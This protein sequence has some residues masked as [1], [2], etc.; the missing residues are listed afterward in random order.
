[1]CVRWRVP[2][3]PGSYNPGTRDAPTT[4]D[5]NANASPVDNLDAEPDD[6]DLF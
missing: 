3:Y 6:A 4:G 5:K 1:M 2:A